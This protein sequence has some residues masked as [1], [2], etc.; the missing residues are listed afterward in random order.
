MNA[1]LWTLQATLAAI[2]AVSGVAKIS[3][4]KERLIAMGQTGV[5]PFPLPVVRVTAF[6]ELLGAVGILLPWLV[7]VDRYLTPLAAAGF[8]V[9]MIGAVGSHAYLR[10]PRNVALTAL[11]FAAAVF[12]AVGR[13]LAL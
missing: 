12:V 6:C 1:L 9:V 4:P 5:A 10:E 3:Q 13:G 8:A 2:F 11:I 7:G